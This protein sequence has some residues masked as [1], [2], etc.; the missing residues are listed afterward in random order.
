MVLE[1]QARHISTTSSVIV[2]APK[3]RLCSVWHPLGLLHFFL[4]VVVLHIPASRS[5]FPVM[6]LHFAP[7]PKTPLLLLLSVML[8]CS[9][10]MKHP[11]CIFTSWRLLTALSKIC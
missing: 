10:G 2:C 7:S 6:S 3:A 8:T 9:F 5:L 1:A 11:C 4:M